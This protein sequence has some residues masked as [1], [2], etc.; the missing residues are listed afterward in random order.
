M[1]KEIYDWE[2]TLL[3]TIEKVPKFQG[4]RMVMEGTMFLIVEIK[5]G[6]L[7]FPWGISMNAQPII[8]LAQETNVPIVKVIEE[9]LLVGE[10]LYYAKRYRVGYTQVDNPVQVLP[11]QKRN[12]KLEEFNFVAKVLAEKGDIET[13]R[14]YKANFYANKQPKKQTTNRSNQKSRKFKKPTA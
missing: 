10:N 12:Y 6:I 7:Y 1:N 13:L 14:E 3:C 5:D 4:G 8:R 11:Q 9:K 2:G